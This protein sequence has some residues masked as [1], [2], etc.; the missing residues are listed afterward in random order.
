M[1]REKLK[2]LI[3]QKKEIILSPFLKL[4]HKTGVHPDILSYLQIAF[5]ITSLVT[6]IKNPRIAISTII[7]AILLDNLDGAYARYVNKASPRGRFV[8]ITCDYL[9]FLLILTGIL[10]YK[11]ANP[12]LLF[13]FG[14]MCIF[15]FYLATLF[16]TAQAKK[17]AI[18]VMI[19]PTLCKSIVLILYLLYAITKR[20]LFDLGIGIFGIILII[21]FPYYYFKVLKLYKDGNY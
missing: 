11:L 18:K 7:I 13:I 21:G 6:L 16:H 14:T 9:S 8:D 12:I 10:Y 2:N 4:I 19:I 15:V 3:D 1:N 17:I 5:V 20:N